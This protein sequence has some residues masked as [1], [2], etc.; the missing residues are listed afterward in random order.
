MIYE[1]LIKQYEE[2]STEDKNALLVYKSRLGRAI[3]SID[4]NDS[5]IEEIYEQ[6]KKLLNDPQNI[7]MAYTVFK[8]ISFTTIDDFKTSLISIKERLK[9]VTSKITLPTDITVYR[10]LSIKEDDNLLPLAKD[11]LIS[12]SLNI[13]ECNK[14]FILNLILWEHM[15]E[16]SF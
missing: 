3:N 10:A 13:S 9:T 5:E 14:F 12:T 6:Y 7:F 11:I 8:D 16:P 15:L 4:N 2:L 1:D